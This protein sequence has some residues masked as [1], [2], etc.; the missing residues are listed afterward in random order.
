VRSRI[1]YTHAEAGDDRLR[2]IRTA[3]IGDDDLALDVSVRQIG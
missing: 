2:S 3:V 1:L